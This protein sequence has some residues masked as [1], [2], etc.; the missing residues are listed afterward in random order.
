MA[1]RPFACALALALALVGL[2]LV[3]AR[4]RAA[5]Y[6]PPA[7]KLY[8]GITA[9]D[10]ST[11]EQQTGAHAA[12]FQEFITW[13]GTIDWAL[14]PAD[15]NRSRA[16]LAIQTITPSGG[17]VISPG[18][19]ARGLGDGWIEWLGAQLAQRGQPVYLRLFAEM[20]AYW[21]PYSAYNENGSFRG[22]DHSTQAFRQAWRRI[23]LILRGGS[24]RAVDAK[25]HALRMPPVPASVSVLPSAPVAML[26]VPQVWGAPDTPQ[27]APRAYYPGE[28]YVDWVGTDFYSEWPNWAGLDRY[29][30]E[31]PG[32]PFVFGEWAITGRDNPRFVNQLFGWVRAHP[33]VRILMY[34]QG[35]KLSGRLALEHYPASAR[36]IG[37]HLRNALFAPFTPEWQAGAGGSP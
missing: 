3:P 30:D 7:G 17:E 22:S 23:T 34:N 1:R 37:R 14:A 27:N 36:T 32:K 10:P 13:G 26:W 15:Q 18:A 5:T 21:N 16:M 2:A 28:E 29:F 19:I 6:L 33:R 8:A 11:Y 35:Y 4:S 24:V 12:I 20:D 31:F 25:L 9:G